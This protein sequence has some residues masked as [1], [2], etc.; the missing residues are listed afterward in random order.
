MIEGIIL[1][2]ILSSCTFALLASGFTLSYGVS[3]I[4]NLTHGAF[5]MIGTYFY[6][7][8]LDVFSISIPAEFSILSLILP[9]IASTILTGIVASIYYRLTLH[10]ILGDEL[11]TLVVSIS[12]CIVFQQMIYLIFGSLWG[13][14]LPVPELLSGNITIWNVSISYS[15]VL[16]AVTSFCLFVALWLLIATT[17]TGKAMKA[18]SQDHEAAMLMGISTEKMYM[19]TA[20]ISAGLSSIAGVMIVSSTT[21]VGS[22]IMWLQP[23]AISFAIVVLGGLGS[24]KGTLVGG[25]IFGFSRTIVELTVP[26][27]GAIVDAVPFLILLCVL[28]VRP[29]GLF[30]KRVEMED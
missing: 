24:L 15:R 25:L 11:A 3:G 28:V 13:M 12:G 1:H 21:R 14:Q 27:G 22:A 30:G 8:L 23:L 18:L 16:A 26:L 9:V 7:I 20:A 2:G 10:Q 4:I 6:S 5:F 19:L 17:K 29:K